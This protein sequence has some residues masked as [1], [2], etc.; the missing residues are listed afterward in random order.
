MSREHIRLSQQA[1]DSLVKLKR[2]TGIPHWN[3]LWP[4]GVLPVTGGVVPT[5]PRED[6]GRQFRRDDLEDIRWGVCRRVLGAAE[7]PLPPG[8]RGVD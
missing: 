6:P 2:Y 3:T 8:R 5:R 7:G 4:V 1:R